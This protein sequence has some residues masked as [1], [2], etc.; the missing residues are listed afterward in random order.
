MA[1][2]GQVA[3]KIF[4]KTAHRT[5]AW[6]G[7]FLGMG[8]GSNDSLLEPIANVR[9]ELLRKTESSSAAVQLGKGYL[10]RWCANGVTRPRR[11]SIRRGLIFGRS[12]NT[13]V[14]P[15]K[16][17]FGLSAWA[18]APS[19]LKRN[20]RNILNQDLPIFKTVADPGAAIPDTKHRGASQLGQAI[21][22]LGQGQLSIRLS[23][24][25]IATDF[26]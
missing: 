13:R 10:G 9:L 12:L 6:A 11:S 3:L 7:G 25:A 26:D 23:Y 24:S 22:P 15:K 20:S 8:Q 19:T 4:G 18:H 5:E 2:S 17:R 1:E 14:M 16:S 21:D